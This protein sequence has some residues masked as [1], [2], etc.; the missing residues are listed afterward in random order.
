MASRRVSWIFVLQKLACTS[1]GGCP[2]EP[3]TLK[4]RRRSCRQDIDSTWVHSPRLAASSS[5]RR[6]PV[7]RNPD[8]I[9]CQ[10]RNDEPEEKT[11]PRGLP[12]GRSSSAAFTPRNRVSA[13]PRP[14]TWICRVHSR[15]DPPS[16][17]GDSRTPAI[18]EV[19]SARMGGG[20]LACQSPILRAHELGHDRAGAPPP[21][22]ERGRAGTCA[23]GAAGGSRGEGM[24][25]SHFC[26]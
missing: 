21:H 24:K 16:H 6:K 8:W 22:H 1:S 26:P 23:R 11:I 13:T 10:A 18:I 9:P 14:S 2:R 15:G 17:S 20:F 3:A 5:Y 19:D 25:W 12:R 7:S 4:S